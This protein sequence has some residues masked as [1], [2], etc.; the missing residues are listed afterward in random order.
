MN[1]PADQ[2]TLGLFALVVLAVLLLPV[3]GGLADYFTHPETGSI[4]S[5]YL[6]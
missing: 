6:R 2:L 1:R 5:R 3:A 4:E